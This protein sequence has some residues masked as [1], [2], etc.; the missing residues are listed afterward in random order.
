M[1]ANPEKF[2]ATVVGKTFEKHPVFNFESV[3]ITCEEVFKLLGS[4]VHNFQKLK[5]ISFKAVNFFSNK[6]KSNLFE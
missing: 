6:T 3:I 2:Q 1:Q 4:Q 5:N